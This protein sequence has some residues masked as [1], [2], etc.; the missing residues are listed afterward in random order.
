VNT[1]L[2]THTELNIAVSVIM[3][4]AVYYVFL[5]IIRK[6]QKID[7]DAHSGTDSKLMFTKNYF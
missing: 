2:M 3:A 4:I 6:A 5:S 1:M 7:A